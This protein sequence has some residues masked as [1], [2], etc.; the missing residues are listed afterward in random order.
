MTVADVHDSQPTPTGRRSEVLQV[1]FLAH[2]TDELETATT[3]GTA[4]D[5]IVELEQLLHLGDQQQLEAL[6]IPVDAAPARRF[7]T[8]W[9]K[10]S[11]GG[12]QDPDPAP[13]LDRGAA[14]RGR[15]R[16]RCPC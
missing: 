13:P 5:S 1:K 4:P 2:L 16:S 12:A 7:P 15:G 9:R 3:L 6:E 8:I 14:A 10:S 11:R